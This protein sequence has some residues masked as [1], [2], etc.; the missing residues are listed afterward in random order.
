MAAVLFVKP[1]V[2]RAAVPLAAVLAVALLVALAWIFEQPSDLTLV[3]RELK[4]LGFEPKRI[5][6]VGANE[7][8]W[9][10]DMAKTVPGAEFFQIEGNAGLEPD[11]KARGRPYRIAIVGD[12]E[13]TVTFYK[14]CNEGLCSG[15]SSVFQENTVWGEQMAKEERQMTTIDKIVA[16]DGQAPFDMIK[17]DVQGAEIIAMAGATETLKSVQVILAETSNVEYNKGAPGTLEVLNHYDK[18]GFE[19]F[20]ISEI[21]RKRGTGHGIMFQLDFVFVRKVRPRLLLTEVSIHNMRGICMI[22]DSRI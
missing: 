21:H 14:L 16:E 1:L 5:L 8:T 17:I 20:D 2:K 11:L 7:G 3:M 12:E 15:A 10:A 4:G 13:K 18:M 22:S 9:T 19:I 6:D